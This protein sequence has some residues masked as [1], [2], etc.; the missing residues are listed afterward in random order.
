MS[1]IALLPV[2]SHALVLQEVQG[3]CVTCTCYMAGVRFVTNL[4]YLVRPDCCRNT[5]AQIVRE[6]T[7]LKASFKSADLNECRIK[8]L[9]KL[10]SCGVCF[11]FSFQKPQFPRAMISKGN[12]I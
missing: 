10:I 6:L 5:R 1:T 9:Q 12:L 4:I 11:P 2:E 7:D 8:L 3:M